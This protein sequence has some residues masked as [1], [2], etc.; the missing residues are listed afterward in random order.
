MAFAATQ[1]STARSTRLRPATRRR[2]FPGTPLDP[3]RAGMTATTR[4][5][6]MGGN[7][8]NRGRETVLRLRGA[9]DPTEEVVRPVRSA[10]PVPVRGDLAD[11]HLD[12]GPDK[13]ERQGVQHG[14]G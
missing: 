11:Q 5:L 8:A 13:H 7:L 4:G 3:P 9:G 10:G 12:P 2:F 6:D 14:G 1:A